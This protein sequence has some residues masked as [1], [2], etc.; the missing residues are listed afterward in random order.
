MVELFVI[1]VKSVKSG[2]G[3]YLSRQTRKGDD[4]IIIEFIPNIIDSDVVADVLN[5]V[6]Y[7]TRGSAEKTAQL[8]L[9][10]A[11]ERYPNAVLE[12]D[13]VTHQISLSESQ[14]ISQMVWSYK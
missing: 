4:G 10:K 12:A 2:K 13:V 9:D 6:G 8:I 1:K 5:V 14:K 7:Y 3:G 11:E